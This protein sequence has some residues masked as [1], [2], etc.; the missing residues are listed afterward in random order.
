VLQRAEAGDPCHQ[1]TDDAD[2]VGHRRDD[3]G[4]APLVMSAHDL[5]RET[6]HADAV[7]LRIDPF[8]SYDGTQL[9]VEITDQ[10][11][12]RATRDAHRHGGCLPPL[13]SEGNQQSH[14]CG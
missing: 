3:P 14:A 11:H 10:I 4:Q 12:R 13:R 6:T 8:T 2:R 1:L 9:L 7:H 5:L